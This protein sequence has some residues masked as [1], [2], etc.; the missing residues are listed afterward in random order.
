VV[1][2][3][4]DFA[5]A[6]AR[7]RGVLHTAT[8]RMRLAV[9]AV[10]AALSA[11]PAAGGGARGLLPAAASPAPGG[12]E[13]AVTDPVAFGGPAV[14]T[15]LR[16]VRRTGAHAVRLHLEWRRVAPTG[17]HKPAAF[18]AADP[19]EP[20][21]RWSGFD[22]Q[23][24]LA[25]AAGLEP[26]VSVQVA[27]E[28]AERS[29]TGAEG[30][31]NPSPSEFGS[32]ARAAARRYGG[33]FR[34]LPR[35][36]Y[37]QA[38]NEPNLD[39]FLMPQFQGGA[40]VSP[41]AYRA[42]LNAFAAAV[43]SIH[44]D[45]VVIAGGTS[46]FGE[47]NRAVSP[48]RFMRE[49]LCIRPSCSARVTFDVWAHHPYTNGG[50]THQARQPDD[51]SLGD[52]PDMRRLLDTAWRTKHIR[53]ARRPA[54]WVTEFS[55]DS[56]PP[57]RY[58]VPLSLHGRWVSEAM[59]R[60]WRAGVSL[61]T[62]FQLRDEPLGTSNF[63]SGLYFSTGTGYRLTRAKPALTAFRFPFVALRSGSRTLVWG[64]TPGGNPAQVAV[65]QQSGR[66]WKRVAVLRTTPLGIFTARLQSKPVGRFRGR[67][68]GGAD[69]SL[70]FAAKAPP[71]LKLENP[72]GR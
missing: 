25:A 65:E 37:W 71:D 59:Y 61:V 36:R 27:P 28:W 20:A 63:Q 58:A 55:W 49:L 34:G 23:V 44:R 38:W 46:P 18:N 56:Y 57:D 2:E 11:L 12:L 7:R 32:F 62:W 29:P 8:V 39:W 51:V 35:V 48:L 14:Q 66:A 33:G 42:L 19:A 22:R 53:A 41:A 70:P 4:K 50:P 21:Y 3:G 69:L 26:I 60:M 24:E 64:R 9:A 5:S 45:N 31:R 67:V 47:I 30:T 13:T 15:A 52:L 1:A 43:K 17:S 6:G 40:A 10:L 68:L 54:F 16:G 72:F